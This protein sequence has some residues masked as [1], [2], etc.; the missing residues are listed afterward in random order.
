MTAVWVIVEFPDA[1]AAGAA[2]LSGVQVSS[3]PAYGDGETTFVYQAE[4]DG[5]AQS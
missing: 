4:I 2:R 3:E 5:P 1:E